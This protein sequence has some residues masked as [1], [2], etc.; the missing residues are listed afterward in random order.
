MQPAE[1]GPQHSLVGS[2]LVELALV[3]VLVLVLVQAAMWAGGVLHAMQGPTP[4]HGRKRK[5]DRTERTRCC[6]PLGS[7]AAG[8]RN[9]ECVAKKLRTVG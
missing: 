5:S 9:C 7:R 8:S 1:N 4:R 3:L 2:R 6:D